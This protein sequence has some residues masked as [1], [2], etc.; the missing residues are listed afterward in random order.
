[1]RVNI[2]SRLMKSI[3]LLFLTTLIIN[4]VFAQENLSV[5]KINQLFENINKHS[6]N[7]A[8]LVL[9]F[10]ILIASLYY[11]SKFREMA[12]FQRTNAKISGYIFLILA[13]ILFT[14]S[15]INFFNLKFFVLSLLSFVLGV[16]FIKI[17]SKS[18]KKSKK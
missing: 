2:I 4:T 17:T 6:E 11:L 3:I 18:Q 15:F 5:E 12:D 13:F 1:M 8:N 16:V 7:K 9:L 14:L 10:I